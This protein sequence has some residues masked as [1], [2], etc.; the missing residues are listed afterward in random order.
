MLKIIDYPM[1][2][3]GVGIGGIAFPLLT[4][5]GTCLHNITLGM[6][7]GESVRS[8]IQITPIAIVV[9]DHLLSLPGLEQIALYEHWEGLG[10]QLFI[11]RS[12][13][14]DCEELLEVLER[15]LIELSNIEPNINVMEQMIAEARRCLDIPVFLIESFFACTTS[16]LDPR[17][18]ATYQTNNFQAQRIRHKQ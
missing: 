6:P 1:N 7:N 15:Y 11:D 18:Q 8:E 2:R 9:R 17:S 4:P 5:N 13:A 14:L 16:L 10:R 3:D 12:A